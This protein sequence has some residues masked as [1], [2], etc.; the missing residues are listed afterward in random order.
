MALEA[1]IYEEITR[2]YMGSFQN[3]E[4]AIRAYDMKAIELHGEFATTNKPKE[5]YLSRAK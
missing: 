3:L 5:M 2:K 4:D 1:R